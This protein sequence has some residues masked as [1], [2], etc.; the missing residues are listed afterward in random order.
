MAIRQSL[1]RWAR[2]HASACRQL[3]SCFYLILRT[4]VESNV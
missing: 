3:F 4:A 1:T 2:E